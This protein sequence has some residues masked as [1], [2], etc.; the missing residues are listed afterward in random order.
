MNKH[1]SVPFQSVRLKPLA[2]GVIAACLSFSSASSYAQAEFDPPEGE[3]IINEKVVLET[4]DTT[5]SPI[6]IHLSGDDTNNKDTKLTF[7][8]KV[9][10]NYDGTQRPNSNWSAY[11]IWISNS[12]NHKAALTLNGALDMDIKG[13]TNMLVGLMSGS[14]YNPT[15]GAQGQDNGTTMYVNGP[16]SMDISGNSVTAA[17]AGSHFRNNTNP[18]GKIV[19]GSSNDIERKNVFNITSDW[20]SGVNKD[21]DSD[22]AIGLSAFDDGEIAVNRDTDINLTIKNF[23][24]TDNSGYYPDEFC[25]EAAAVYVDNNSI[26]SLGKNTN[27]NINVHAFNDVKSMSNFGAP[28]FGFSVGKHDT[29]YAGKN[30]HVT[31]SGNTEINLYKTA[32][33]STSRLE[34]LQMTG[35]G[36]FGGSTVTTDSTSALTINVKLEKGSSADDIDQNTKDIVGL[37]ASDSAADYTYGVT[38][39]GSITVNGALTISL[40]ETVNP[41][42]DFFAAIKTSRNGLN[43]RKNGGEIR[44]D[45]TN[46]R[47]PVSVTGM[48]E[49]EGGTITINLAGQQSV[50]TSNITQDEDEVS[51]VNLSLNDGSTWNVLESVG[52]S[53]RPGNL[54]VNTPL[55]IVTELTL[56]NGVL[57]LSRPDSLSDFKQMFGGYEIVRVK[58]NLSSQNGLFIFDADIGKDEIVG[59]WNSDDGEPDTVASVDQVIV[60][61]NAT[62]SG[63]VEVNFI[64]PQNI[65]ADKFYSLN[66]L[67]RQNDGSMTLTGPDGKDAFTGRGMVSMWSLRFVPEGQSDKLADND[68]RESLTNKGDGKGDWYL[69]RYDYDVPDPEPEPDPDTPE[70]PD[71]PNPDDKP[72]PNPDPVLP[73]EVDTNLNIGTSASQALAYFADLDDLRERIGEVRYGAQSGVWAKAFTKQDRMTGSGRHGFKQEGYGINVGYDTFASVDEDGAWL[74]GGALRYGHADQEG[75]ASTGRGSGDLDEYSAK[76]YATY[77]HKGG[78]YADFVVQAGHYEQELDGLDNT[79]KGTSHADYDTFGTGVSVEVGHMFTLNNGEDDRPWFNHWFIEPQAQLAYFF[80]D[81]ADYTTSTGLKVSQDNADFLTGRLGVVIGKKFNYGSNDELD[82]RYFQIAL[83][84]GI[85]H[86]FLGDQSIKYTGVDGVSRS[87]DADDIDGTRAYYGVN[88][89]WQL[90]DDLRIYAQFDR[91]EGEHYEKDYDVSAG[92]KYSF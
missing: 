35:V 59:E 83:I 92:L 25:D 34:S 75:Y 18:G 72:I 76:L 46:T 63:N 7:N 84:G 81:G 51:E 53:K 58:S 89:D 66:W 67:V 60:E 4:T 27:L 33:V 26:F 39:H 21:K 79:G 2:A 85:K 82:K 44:I 57:N 69:V 8:N 88:L 1:T 37:W 56:N 61:G 6:G 28:V 3:E 11:G 43:A 90:S 42:L 91:E 9:S 70:E 17:V 24:T 31:L 77:M 52:N 23:K 40:P 32:N 48:I 16:V 71:H 86:E 47:A 19:F 50:L 80:A 38:E 65:P 41:A 55:N 20:T 14:S 13:T 29:V 10:I 5:V 78:S 64:N 45:N 68:Y 62:G 49:A 22:W 74:V 73:P 36:A 54:Y 87:F 15:G 12:V 30:S